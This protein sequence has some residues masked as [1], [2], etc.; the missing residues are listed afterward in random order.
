MLRECQIYWEP[1]RLLK[2]WMISLRGWADL[3]KDLI[4]P[5]TFLREQLLFSGTW[6]DENYYLS[7]LLWWTEMWK[8][9]LGQ[10]IYLFIYLLKKFM[11]HHKSLNFVHTWKYVFT[12]EV[13][14]LIWIWLNSYVYFE[15]GP[16]G[17]KIL[18]DQVAVRTLPGKLVNTASMYLQCLC[19][20]ALKVTG[21]TLK[22][23]FPAQLLGRS[24]QIC[25][26]DHVRTSEDGFF[27]GFNCI[28][29]WYKSIKY[30][31]NDDC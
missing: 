1:G 2:L 7:N 28:K 10:F 16:Q 31:P 3:W 25:T 11:C 6:F 5:Q 23:K 13:V 4:P 17:D 22:V 14:R 15:V 19:I 30:M 8:V 27:P 24:P 21:T 29:F 12:Q 20:R 18:E 9:L 26:V